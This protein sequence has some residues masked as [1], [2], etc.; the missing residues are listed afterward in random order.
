MSNPIRRTQA[1]VKDQR[2][3]TGLE[4]AIILIAFVVAASVFAFPVLSTGI[5]SAERGKETIHAGLR[6]ARSS[7]ELK[8][9]VIAIGVSDKALSSADTVWLAQTNVTGTATTT[10]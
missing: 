9:S 8:G 5:F 7:A 2:G 1:L 6:E 3:G 4:T 10:A